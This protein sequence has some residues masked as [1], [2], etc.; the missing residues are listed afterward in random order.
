MNVSKSPEKKRTGI[1]VLGMHRSGTSVLT[2]I[3]NILGAALPVNCLGANE[4][5]ATGHWEP[6]SLIWLHEQMLQESGSQWDDWRSFEF[7]RMPPDRQA[8]FTYE[9]SR[10]LR[11]EYETAPIFV[12]KEPRISRFVPLY[13][14]AFKMWGVEPKFVLTNRNPLEVAASLHVRDKI[15]RGYAL[16]IW[17]RHELDAERATRGHSRTFVSYEGMLDDKWPIIEKIV[18]L[19]EDT[20]F[21]LTE[22]SDNEIDEFLSPRYRHHQ[23]AIEDLESEVPVLNWVKEAYFAF[24]RLEVDANDRRATSVLD[25]VNAEFDTLSGTFGTIFVS[26]SNTRTQILRE[27]HEEE[28]HDLTHTI[29]ALRQQI[30]DL[31]GELAQRVSSNIQV[32]ERLEA[33]NLSLDAILKSKTYRLSTV[34]KRIYRF[35]IWK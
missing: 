35:L 1:I 12:L 32:G 26:E 33:A 15:T 25:R 5:N 18:K 27:L 14:A 34:F 8:H 11:E 23:M 7:T 16:L 13:I 10:L 20:A 28:V 30:M 19:V 21:V 3:I 22:G 24:K 17:L 29:G 2:R 4:S 6:R 31:R 9:I